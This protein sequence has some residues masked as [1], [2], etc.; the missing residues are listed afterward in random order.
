MKFSVHLTTHLCVC[1]L[2]FAIP[3]HA[4]RRAMA[5]AAVFQHDHILSQ[6]DIAGHSRAPLSPL[7][8][9]P[10]NRRKEG[11]RQRKKQKKSTFYGGS[12][13][14]SSPSVPS[15]SSSGGFLAVTMHPTLVSQDRLRRLSLPQVSEG[16]LGVS[17]RRPSLYPSTNAWSVRP[18]P[19]P[20]EEGLLLGGNCWA[21]TAGRELLMGIAEWEFWVRISG[22][23]CGWRCGW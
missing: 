18:T 2:L 23:R 16:P 17:I 8:Q 10:P 9:R 6:T 22:R 19:A 13:P 11:I 20:S 3:L 4:A 1:Y 7:P 21:G 5:A 12:S 15:T 14:P